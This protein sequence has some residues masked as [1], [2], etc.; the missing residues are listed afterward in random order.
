MPFAG[1]E[2]QTARRHRPDHLWASVLRPVVYVRRST[3]DPEQVERAPVGQRHQLD[4]TPALRA[5]AGEAQRMPA[6]RVH[7]AERQLGHV[8]DGGVEQVR[9]R[10]APVEVCEY[11]GTRKAGF[12]NPASLSSAAIGETR[13]QA[14]PL[15]VDQSGRRRSQQQRIEEP[16]ALSSRA[17]PRAVARLKAAGQVRPDR[18]M[19]AALS[20]QPPPRHVLSGCR[21]EYLP[22]L[23]RASPPLNLA[24]DQPW[25][26]YQQLGGR[27]D[28]PRCCSARR[29]VTGSESTS[30]SGW[31][32]RTGISAAAHI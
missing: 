27:L 6:E 2:R 20:N 29:A 8:V 1:R 19:P 32:L 11:R 22:R 10:L 28:F 16:W 5:F 9:A 24:P 14:I 21:H 17:A 25:D 31:S 26:L 23:W 4:L 3:A 7:S 30:Q 18:G 13:G 15:V 12:P